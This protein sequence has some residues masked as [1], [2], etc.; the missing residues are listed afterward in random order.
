MNPTAVISMTSYGTIRNTTDK[1]GFHTF[2]LSS[3]AR[4][5]CGRRD[6]WRA[7][8]PRPYIHGSTERIRTVDEEEHIVH[9]QRHPRRRI[10]TGT[11]PAGSF[12]MPRRRR[13][14]KEC[15]QTHGEAAGARLR[16]V[17]SMYSHRR[18]ESVTALCGAYMKQNVSL[19]KSAHKGRPGVPV[20][21]ILM[22]PGRRR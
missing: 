18:E 3:L 13:I 7:Y 4:R 10:L 14:S 19:K 6:C 22:A 5:G 21:Q 9:L 11:T 8:T 15:R 12:L 17:C 16:H 2:F 1:Q 20:L